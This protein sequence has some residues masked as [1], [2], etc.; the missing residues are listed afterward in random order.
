MYLQHL[1]AT[2]LVMVLN[3]SQQVIDS[4][5]CLQEPRGQSAG[6]GELPTQGTKRL[7]PVESSFSRLLY[8]QA[9]FLTT[10]S[11]NGDRPCPQGW[12]TLTHISTPGIWQQSAFPWP[13]TLR[14][15][16]CLPRNLLNPRFPKE[17]SLTAPTPLLPQFLAMH[18]SG[19]SSILL[20]WP[21]P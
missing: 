17:P 20:C 19:P 15:P 12:V 11:V 3:E 14:E 6:T 8:R 7:S 2:E 9:T 10:L 1:H 5:S 4:L 16:S 21:H 13:C 18:S